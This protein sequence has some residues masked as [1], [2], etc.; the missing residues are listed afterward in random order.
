MLDQFLV[1]DAKPIMTLSGVQLRLSKAQVPKTK[2]RDHMVIVPYASVVG[3]LM[4]TMVCTRSDI[5]HAVGVVSY[6]MG[7]LGT[8]HWETVKWLLRYLK[9]ISSMA[10]CFRKGSIGL[11]GFI[12]VDLGGDLDRW[13]STFSYVFTWGGTP[14]SWM[15]RLQ[16]CV[17]LS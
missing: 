17:A 6:Y 11:E 12:N 1:Q 4:Y 10:L 14:A 15:L 8:A 7:N 3:S 5:S 2:E 9:G 13:K 16:N